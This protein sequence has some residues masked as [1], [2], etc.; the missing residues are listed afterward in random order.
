MEIK[1][2]IEMTTVDVS[3][4][5][6]EKDI[7]IIPFGTLEAHGR[8]LPLSTDTICAEKI[9][10]AIAKRFNLLLAPPLHYGITGSLIKFSGGTTNTPTTYYNF[11]K[12]ILV[13]LHKQGFRKFI[14]VNGHGGNNSTLN[15][16]ARDLYKEYLDN[17]IVIHWWMLIEDIT[18]DIF[19]GS[20]GHAG[21]DETSA[22]V[23]FAPEL[24]KWSYLEE[25]TGYK[26][27]NGI[28]P[29]PPPGNVLFYQDDYVFPYED[30]E[31][32]KLFME[33]TIDRILKIVETILKGWKVI[34]DV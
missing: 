32:A 12:E 34:I 9:S 18:K 4:Y 27:H 23:Y 5:L 15:S 11:V 6:K 17:F 19:N 10:E 22:I 7:I 29:Y 3:R 2:L 16:L 31:K 33:K 1:R 28:I 30:K 13:S 24:I 26:Y 14:L 8:H 20:G 25:I 21:V